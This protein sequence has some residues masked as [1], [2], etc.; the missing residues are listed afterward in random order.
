MNIFQEAASKENKTLNVIFGSITF[1]LLIAA[2][3]L[4]L[5]HHPFANTINLW[6]AK[7]MGDDKYF[8]ALTILLLVLPPLLILLPVKL[9][10]FKF[11]KK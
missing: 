5:T 4:T 1:G 9:L 10:V 2:T 6:Q 3:Y 8:P 11:F 7:L